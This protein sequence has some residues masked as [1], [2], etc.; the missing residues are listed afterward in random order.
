M[1]LLLEFDGG[2]YPPYRE[3]ILGRVVVEAPLVLA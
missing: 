1:L 3:S 2:R